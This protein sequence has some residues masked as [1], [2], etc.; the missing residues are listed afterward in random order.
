[1]EITNK[2]PRFLGLPAKAQSSAD[3]ALRDYQKIQ[4]RVS[5]KGLMVDIVK[6]YFEKIMGKKVRA[7]F[8]LSVAQI[9]SSTFQIKLDRLAKRNRTALLCWYAEN[10]V[11]IAPSLQSVILQYAKD[12]DFCS[13][14]ENHPMTMEQLF[15][16]E[17]EQTETNPS[18]M[19][20]D[21]SNIECLINKH[22]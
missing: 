13:Y 8:I 10:W 22:N 5:Q 21:V 9:L 7:S 6:A 19:K 3:Q 4:S 12:P 20:I 16:K 11:K 1:M 14:E 15:P 17:T 18:N 2:K